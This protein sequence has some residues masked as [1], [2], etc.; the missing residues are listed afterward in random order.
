M[1]ARRFHRTIYPANWKAVSEYV[2][3]T[4]ALGRCECTGQCGLHCTHPGP[5]RCTE[6]HGF[7]AQWARGL[8]VLTAAHTC[9][10]EPLC[11]DLAHLLVMCQRCHMRMDQ[12]LHQRHAAETRALA[13]QIGA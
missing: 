11:A 3:F 6:R 9:A 1:P 8:I 4:R 7:L 13:Q 12:A 10:C 5:R 2:R